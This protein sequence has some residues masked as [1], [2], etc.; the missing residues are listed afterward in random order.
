MNINEKAAYIKGLA[1]G[2]KLDENTAE[3]KILTALIDL[4]TEITDTLQEV[5]E[6][7]DYLNDYIEEIDEDLGE[8]EEYLVDEEFCD[9]DCDCGCDDDDDY[10]DDE[11][12]YE[13]ECPS[14]GEKICFNSS[15]NPEEL[16][17]PACNEKIECVIEEDDLKAIDGE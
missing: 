3:G 11:E 6:S 7:L 1:E 10:D 4:V 16:V 17:C 5:D 12:Y 8:I 2:L 14:C 13:V 9:C 15:V